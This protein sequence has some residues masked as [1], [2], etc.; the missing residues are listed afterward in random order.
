M[1]YFTQ[2]A[3]LAVHNFVSAATGVAIAVALIRGLVRKQ[4]ESIGNFWADLTRCTLYVLL[5]L[6]LLIAIVLAEQGVPQT[7]SGYPTATTVE[8]AQQQIPLGPV[9]S[10]IAIKQLGTNGGGFYGQN[11]AHPFENPTP[12]T[13]FIEVFVI[14]WLGSAL[15]YIFGLTTGDRRQGW[16]VWSAMFALFVV[17]FTVLW[18]AELQ[19]NPA[20]GLTTAYHLLDATRLESG[21]LQPAREW[22]DPVELLREAI[23]RAGMPENAVRLRIPTN[24]PTIFVDGG[25]IEQ[26]LGTLL[27]NAAVYL[28]PQA[29]EASISLDNNSLIFS[30]ADHGPGLAPGEDAKIFEKFY[31]GPGKP[32]GGLGLGLP[33]HDNW[34][35]RTAA[36]S[37]R[38]TARTAARA[39]RFGCR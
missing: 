12:L 38:A 9:A 10:Q 7:F 33:S 3:G 22:C 23:T 15:V 32:P 8:G 39:F 17:G 30:V 31:R 6:S 35:R 29:I 28:G 20:L 11:S 24:L 16:A 26:S 2:M 19:P 5:P 37:S 14:F 1:S 18:W 25:L 34:S 27:H 4:A 13:N 36:K 21:L